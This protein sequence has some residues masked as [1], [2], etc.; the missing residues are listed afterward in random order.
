[1]FQ[2]SVFHTT[3]DAPWFFYGGSANK[4]RLG[5]GRLVE[6]VRAI[7]RPCAAGTRAGACDDKCASAYKGA[8]TLT[9]TLTNGGVYNKQDESYYKKTRQ[10]LFHILFGTHKN[11][12]T[13]GQRRSGVHTDPLDADAFPAVSIALFEN[14]DAKQ[15]TWLNNRAVENT[16]YIYATAP[17]RSHITST[18]TTNQ[19]HP[20]SQ[21]PNTFTNRPR[22]TSATEYPV[23]YVSVHIPRCVCFHTAGER[24]VSRPTHATHARLRTFEYTSHAP[25]AFSS[26]ASA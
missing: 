7:N 8:D 12:G 5:D 24:V 17:T 22:P 21:H 13:A 18:T 26:Q 9:H 6:H 20:A 23:A 1:M 14:Q 15:S 4:L 3:G 25:S 10:R 16:A 19:P 2:S 11:R